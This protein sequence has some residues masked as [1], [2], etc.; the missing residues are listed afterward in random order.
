MHMAFNVMQKDGSETAWLACRRQRV[1]I[2]QSY[3]YI[4]I[5]TGHHSHLVYHKVVY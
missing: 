5:A 3:I 1:G 2:Y 4:Y